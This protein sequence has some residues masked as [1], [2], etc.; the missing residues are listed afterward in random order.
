MNQFK[1]RLH[2]LYLG[3]CLTAA[4]LYADIIHLLPK[5]QQVTAQSGQFS[6]SSSVRLVLPALPADAPRVEAELRE[7]IATQGGTVS[8]ELTVPY[9]R[10][11]LVDNVA[12]AEFQDEA[13]RLSVSSDSILIQAK[14]A[15]G[16]LRAAQTMQQLAEDRANTLPACLITDWAAWKVRG[17]MHDTGRSY[18]PFEELKREIVRLARY[19][20]NVFHWHLTDNQ[21]WRLESKVYPQ[22]NAAA[23]YERHHAQFYTIEQAKELVA[24]AKSYGIAVI[25][26]IDMPGHSLA[27]RKAMGHS[28]LTPQGLEEMKA[29][30]REACETF[31]GTEFLHIGTDELRAADQGTI[32]WTAFVPQITDLI[33]S[34]GKKVM[35]W[36]PGY[37]Y[38]PGQVDM[39]QMWS[40]NGRPTPGVPA[41]DSRYFYINHYD[42]YADIVGLYNSNIAN[43]P[44]G[45]AQYAG[46]IIGIWND[47]LMSS[48]DAIIK[49]NAFYTSMLA[50]AER[51]WLGGGKTYIETSGVK[52]DPFNADFKDWE[53]RLLFHKANHLS[54]AP[55]AY[56][57][58]TNVH[59][60]ITDAF[61]NGGNTLMAFPPET[62]P[63]A[64]T[65]IYNGTTYKTIPATGAGIYLRHVWGN[66]V[67]ALFANPQTNSTSYAYTYVYSPKAQTVGAQIEFQNYSRSESDLAAPQGKWDY[68]NSKI[69]V[70]DSLIAPPI[71][72]NTHSTRTNETALGNENFPARPLT[73][74][75]LKEGWNKVLIKLPVTSFS[76]SA[77]RLV[78]WMFTFVLTTPDGKNAVPDLIYSPE[79]SLQPYNTLLLQAVE[80][81]EAT[82]RNSRKGSEPGTYGIRAQQKLSQAIAAT[83][84]A[85]NAI[86][87]ED[88]ATAAATA[89]QT[90]VDSFL[91]D[92]NRPQ[93]STA[94]KQYWYYL[95]TPQREANRAIAFQGA[96][97]HLVG[98]PYVPNQ[99]KFLWKLE[100]VSTGVFRLIN[101]TSNTAI[102]VTAPYNSA[103]SATTAATTASQGW[104][105]SPI[106]ANGCFTISSDTVQ[107][108]QTGSGQSYKIFNW[109]GGSN[110][111]DAGCQ[112][113]FSTGRIDGADLNDSIAMLVG[114]C[115]MF[116]TNISV[117]TQP[118][119][120][121]PEQVTAFEQTLTALGKALIDGQTSDT[122][123][124][125]MYKDLDTALSHLRQNLLLPQA[126]TP[127][128]TYWYQLISVRENR[129]VTA[130]TAGA[131]LKGQAAAT[132]S[133][134]QLWRLQPIGT[135]SFALFNKAI[136]AFI[137]PASSTLIAKSG[138][139]TTADAWTFTPIHVSDYFI[140]TAGSAQFN[141][142][143]AGTSY[144]INNWGNGTNTTDLGCRYFLRLHKTLITSLP[145]HTTDA[146][147]HFSIRQ[148]RL[149]TTL[150]PADIKVFA[151][152]GTLLNPTDELPLGTVLV[153]TPTGT[154]KLAV[155]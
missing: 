111:T 27:F 138:T 89:L 29:I 131:V 47:R 80:Q 125:N 24:L 20:I 103:L 102:D 115:Q 17:Y 40:S 126:S 104:S 51:A 88:E 69:W 112:W 122:Q 5:P 60:R 14:T 48:Y 106:H 91:T 119:S 85:I 134:A 65:Y 143:N 38:Q 30:V 136:N 109:G 75:A 145:H 133:D 98:Q 1:Q 74:I 121:A 57:K 55:I 18:L 64:N 100:E 56:V 141:Q 81:A 11:E 83:R 129:A 92:V 12:N 22:L 59:W 45:N 110:N 153:K 42:Q 86:G 7:L 13:Y 35:S 62:E 3:L 140:I 128:T 25:P 79:K 46:I 120:Y 58:Q 71:W 124:R 33:H 66:Y 147:H 82:L 127:D 118:G 21:G 90:A 54:D 26:E 95:T 43:Q 84:L 113:A 139:P 78:K 4:P 16:A 39:T 142:G 152:N 52:L 37:H 93:I 50:M 149:H 87:S 67:P 10:V 155:H 41:V 72:S 99:D 15:L 9:I 123:L 97:A 73:Q 19:K 53:R 49:E 28:M 31:E 94:Q 107:L 108:N 146:G 77:V 144:N 23:S 68:N 117:G 63:T 76:L 150:R 70:N 36:A 154:Y 116:L 96:G 44:K 132:D 151:P 32:N 105:I 8:T 130:Q 61:P 135:N 6:L 114:Q 148:R 101:R 34:L 137:S 2:T